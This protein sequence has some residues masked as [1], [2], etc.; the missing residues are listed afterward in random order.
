MTENPRGIIDELAHAPEDELVE[1][2]SEEHISVAELQR[3]RSHPV[4]NIALII[5]TLVAI[6]LPFGIG[7]NLAMNHS[8]SVL[9]MLEN[10]DPRGIALV[11]WSVTVLCF[12]SLAMAIMES[13][14]VGWGSVTLIFLAIEQFISGCTLLQR[15][16]WY[17]TNVVYGQSAYYANAANAGIIT[18]AIGLGIFALLYVAILIFV[19]KNSPL[20]VLARSWAAIGSFF[21]IEVFSILIAIFGGIV[22]LG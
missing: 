10:Y 9:A 8:D 18:A 15:N 11:A 1:E 21:I 3:K 13:S 14:P 17:A 19:K 12:I 20:N 2:A 16:F 4:R 22:S 7:R 6:L 5:A